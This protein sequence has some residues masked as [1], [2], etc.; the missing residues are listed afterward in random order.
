MIPAFSNPQGRDSFGR[1]LDEASVRA[2]IHTNSRVMHEREEQL[3]YVEAAYRDPRRAKQ[4][5]DELVARD[6]PL[7]A[8]RRIT[9]EP[10]TLG[11][12]Q[13]RTGLLAGAA[14]RAERARAEIVADA[15][16]D[17]VRRVAEAEGLAEHAYRRSVE[18][19]RRADAVPIPALSERALAALQAIGSARGQTAQAEAYEALRADRDLHREVRAFTA[20]MEQRFGADGVRAITRAE[21]QAGAFRSR[22]VAPQHQDALD[23][24]ARALH[25]V[26]LGE[27]MTATREAER[28]DAR[29]SLRQ[30]RGARM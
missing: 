28:A 25:S 8:A 6:G 5:L 21:G 27:R 3:A 15:L 13:G 16:A 24:A 26:K 29:E 18:E 4:R 17:N 11:E 14:A 10:T 7:S 23:R 9:A 20:A 30:G 19:Q 1:G 12:L 22:S 2:A